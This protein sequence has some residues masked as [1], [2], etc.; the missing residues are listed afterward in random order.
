MAEP[1]DDQLWRGVEYT[2]QHVLLPAIDDEW[3][4]AAAIQLVGLA[5]YATGRPVGRADAVVSELADVLASLSENPIVAASASELSGAV[6]DPLAAVGA[7]LAA[8]VYDDGPD[9]DEIR[10]VLRPVL[11]RQLADELA[12][13]S[14][15]VPYFRGQIDG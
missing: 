11:V 6:D 13:T 10:A 1:T 9:G 12:V 2:V 14:S 4:R 7:V 8:A 5:R 15:L 3:A